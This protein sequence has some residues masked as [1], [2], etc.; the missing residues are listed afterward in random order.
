MPLKN[1]PTKN[2]MVAKIIST[3]TTFMMVPWVLREII[4]FIRGAEL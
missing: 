4:C 1:G 2:R 3:A